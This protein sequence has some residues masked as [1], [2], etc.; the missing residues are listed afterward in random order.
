MDKRLLAGVSAAIF[1]AFSWSLGFIAPYVTGAYSI[2]D[3]AVCRFLLSGILGL[4][5]LISL[6][7]NGCRL[8]PLDWMVAA[9]LGF[10]GYVGYF[11]TIMAAVLY[12]GPVVPPAFVAVVPVVLAIAGNIGR[13]GVPWR[14][15]ALP[16]LLTIMGLLLVNASMVGI[17]DDST[18]SI[19][20][21]IGLS[22]AA[23]SLWTLFGLTN[24]AALRKRPAM[25][26]RIW[27][28][29]MVIGGSVETVAFV[30]IGASLGLLKIFQLGLRWD[31][32]G[33]IFVAALA[34]A[35][36]GSIGGSW[37][38]TIASRR[39]PIGLAGQLLVTETVFATS[40]GLIAHH[41][42]PTWLEASG[43][44]ALLLGVVSAIG[45]FHRQTQMDAKYAARG[46]G[47]AREDGQS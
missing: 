8:S 29:A 17:A 40:F 39:L 46:F 21:G 7:G 41:R 30:P 38:W 42:W 3:L 5:I 43:M 6:R 12:A 45:A 25:D 15:L 10:I 24:R 22:V 13:G 9:W 44:T 16:L 28:A 1:A 14:S 36:V 18:G 26:A 23:V 31:A 35:A 27:T 37:A 20:I 4:A 34:L 19:G 32:F 47:P 33:P 11:V 2:Y